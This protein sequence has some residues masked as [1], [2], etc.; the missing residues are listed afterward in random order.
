MTRSSD[1]RD[2]PLA[3]CGQLDPEP[4]LWMANGPSIRAN[5]PAETSRTSAELAIECQLGRPG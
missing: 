2:R 1:L 5:S 4:V 3:D